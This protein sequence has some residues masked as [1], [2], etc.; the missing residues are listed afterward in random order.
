MIATEG[1]WFWEDGA[2]SHEASQSWRT[3]SE[4]VI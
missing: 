2:Q 4:Y 3:G 1:P